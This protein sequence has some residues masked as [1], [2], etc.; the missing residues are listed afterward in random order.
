MDINELRERLRAIDR[1]AALKKKM[2]T[3]EYVRQNAKYKIGDILTDGAVIIQVA[4]IKFQVV[5]YQTGA[6]VVIFYEG[7]KL[8][9]DHEPSPFGIYGFVYEKHASKFCGNEATDD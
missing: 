2:A 4:E 9:P 8:S 7:M 3:Y 1:S 6:D 5:E